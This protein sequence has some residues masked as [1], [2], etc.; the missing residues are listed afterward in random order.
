MNTSLSQLIPDVEPRVARAAASQALAPTARQD[1]FFSPVLIRLATFADRPALERLAQLDSSPRPEGQSL[2]GQVRGQVVVA[3]S[4]V[5]GTS[6]A[7]PFMA[8]GP[9]LELVQLRARQLGAQ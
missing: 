1:P 6:I 3:V 9:I 5:D 8:T 7:D 4:L 2:I